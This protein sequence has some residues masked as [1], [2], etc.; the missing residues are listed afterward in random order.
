LNGPRLIFVGKIVQP[1]LYLFVTRQA[2]KAG[3]NLQ[4]CLVTDRFRSWRALAN[5]E[6]GK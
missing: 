5:W 6:A 3:G 2:S 4:L 1:A